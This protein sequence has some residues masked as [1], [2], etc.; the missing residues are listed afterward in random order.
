[1]WYN[2]VPKNLTTQ[3]GPFFL[4]ISE[5]FFHFEEFYGGKKVESFYELHP[6]LHLKR[7]QEKICCGLFQI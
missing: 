2:T 5:Y 1:M 7:V 4:P 3:F 6:P